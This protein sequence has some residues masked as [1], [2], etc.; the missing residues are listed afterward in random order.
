MAAG[1]SPRSK[2]PQKTH[3]RSAPGH[4][5]KPARLVAAG[6]HD[7]GDGRARQGPALETAGRAIH[8]PWPST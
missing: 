7:R 6:A 2:I 5:G 8:R 1:A 3:N 4:G